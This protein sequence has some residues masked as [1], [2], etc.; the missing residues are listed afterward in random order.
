MLKSVII[1]AIVATT[2]FG[3]TSQTDKVSQVTKDVNSSTITD[4][5]AYISENID[6]LEKEENKTSQW[7]IKDRKKRATGESLITKVNEQ[8]LENNKTQPSHNDHNYS[9]LN[10]LSFFHDIN[11][12]KESFN[13]VTTLL[14]IPDDNDLTKSQKEDIEKILEQKAIVAYSQYSLKDHI[15]TSSLKDINVTVDD[16]SIVTKGVEAKGHYDPSKSL[17]NDSELG[18]ASVEL[19]P[20][21]KKFKGEYFKLENFKATTN[22]ETSGDSLSLNYTVSLKLLDANAD[23]KRSKIEDFNIDMTI[24][25]LNLDAYEELEKYGKENTSSE[26]DDVKLQALSIKL[27]SHKD[28]NIEIK[29]LRIANL[30]T[31]GEQM[32]GL[33]V[34]AKFS[35]DDKQD[36]AKM[37][38]ISPLMA[39][40]ALKADVKIELSK[41][42][43]KAIMKDKRA[44]MLTMLPPKIDGD[45][46][47]Y[48]IKYT[49]GKLTINGQKF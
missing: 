40:S 16:V 18:I 35:L 47:V 20:H 2:L 39:L 45:M 43:M 21:G 12:S 8:S 13:A 15:Y 14:S 27:L 25:N 5:K 24:A 26:I 10:S 7:I 30:I 19:T 42:M 4:L 17:K 37:M 9:R 11:Y 38:A 1:T 36:V 46:I 31:K 23:K 41:D 22:I 44:G 32:G 49:Q 6:K 34:K 3:Q 48:E 28:V 29:D 33:N